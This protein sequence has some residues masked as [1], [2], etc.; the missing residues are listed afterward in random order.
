MKEA[1]KGKDSCAACKYILYLNAEGCSSETTT[2][3]YDKCE[4]DTK[5]SAEAALKDFNCDTYNIAIILACIETEDCSKKVEYDICSDMGYSGIC[6]RNKYGELEYSR[7]CYDLGYD[8]LCNPGYGCYYLS[9]TYRAC[10]PEG[11]K[12]PGERCSMANDCVIGSICLESDSTFYS[13]CWKICKG[14]NDCSNSEVCV[15]TEMGFNVCV[16][17]Q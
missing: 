3:I 6:V 10:L 15:D 12:Y 8:I 9:Y 4:G 14:D 16:S 5:T 11:S 1:C 2:N 17:S 7:I 13:S